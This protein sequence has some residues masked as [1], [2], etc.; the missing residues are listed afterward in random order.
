MFKAS[1][2]CGDGI[3]ARDAPSAGP[4]A[5]A[6]AHHPGEAQ[7]ARQ[8]LLAPGPGQPQRPGGLRQPLSAP[9]PQ[10]GRQESE[11]LP[12]VCHKQLGYL[13]RV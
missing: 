10:A 12:Q 9:V 13:N 2:T 8:T 5:H 1:P 7:R 6:A 4:A 11:Q 3:S